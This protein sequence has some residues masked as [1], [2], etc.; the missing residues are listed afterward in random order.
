M[1]YVQLFES[2]IVV[3]RDDLLVNLGTISEEEGLRLFC[4]YFK[5]TNFR[6]RSQLYFIFLLINLFLKHGVHL[7]HRREF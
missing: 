2:I 6:F 3:A 5:T 1:P 4:L 7:H